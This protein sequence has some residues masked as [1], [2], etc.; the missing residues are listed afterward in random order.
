V[1]FLLFSSCAEEST[2]PLNIYPHLYNYPEPVVYRHSTFPLF[3]KNQWVYAD[4]SYAWYENPKRLVFGASIYLASIDKYTG[5]SDHGKW[6]LTTT[7]GVYN[8]KYA[9][10]CISNDTVYVEDPWNNSALLQPRIAFL[11]SSSIHDTATFQ[12]PWPWSV[13]NVYAYN[14]TFVTPAGIFDNV[15]VYRNN[16]D[17]VNTYFCP[18]IGIISQEEIYDNVLLYKRVLIS[19]HLG[20]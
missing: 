4:T 10:Y 12:G 13:T 7:D 14:H 20:E 16:Y 6:Q 3:K 9:L 18:G 8:T 11:P 19:Y 2:S 1:L 5:E 17:S 15:Y